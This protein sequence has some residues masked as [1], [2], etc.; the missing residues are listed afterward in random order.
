MYTCMFTRVFGGKG[1]FLPPPEMGHIN[2]ITAMYMYVHVP[3]HDTIKVYV[4]IIF[5]YMYIV[6]LLVCIIY[7]SNMYVVC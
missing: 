1:A 7:V 4:R 3:V 6:L 5:I 2:L